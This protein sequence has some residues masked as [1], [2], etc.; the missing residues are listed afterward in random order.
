MPTKWL[1]ERTNGS[2]NEPGMPP[3]R[4]SRGLLE[5]SIALYLKFSTPNPLCSPQPPNLKPKTPQ[6]RTGR[7][8]GRISCWR[9]PSSGRKTPGRRRTRARGKSRQPP[10]PTL[11]PEN[12]KAEGETLEDQE[13]EGAWGIEV[14]LNPKPCT[15]NPEP[16]TLAKVLKNF[17]WKPRPEYGLD[18]F[19]CA[20]K[21][22]REA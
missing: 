6:F 14:A 12:R 9:T 3:Q 17:T 5:E 18:C 8:F 15:L 16:Y 21:R 10:K 19:I 4:A 13:T 1:Q 20:A 7:Q 2:K 22:E 11:K